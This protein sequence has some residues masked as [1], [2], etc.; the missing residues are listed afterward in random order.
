[1]KNKIP[2]ITLSLVQTDLVW[3]DKKANLSKI[4]GLLKG[5]RKSDVI[6]LPEMFTTGFSMEASKLA[7]TMQGETVNWMVKTAAAK[8]SVI[9]GSLI[10]KEGRSYFNR[11]VWVMPNG[12]IYTYDK[13][14]LF[15]PAGEHHHYKEGKEKIIINYKGWNI[16]PFICYDLRFPVWSRNKETEADL[17]IYVANW[18]SPRNFAW[19][20]LLIARAIENQVYVAGVNRIG[21]D[22]RGISHEGSSAV[23]D[24][25]GNTLLKGPDKKSWVQ[26]VQL[27]YSDLVSY[28]ERLPFYRDADKFKL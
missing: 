9:C 1:M 4:N 19:K 20:Q 17:Y 26:N 8:K 28:R 15:S 3:E 13:R 10:I 6:I 14:H 2:A 25:T 16:C 7:E 18:P 24:F 22:G 11:F 5:I 23:Y 21:K 12:E 27:K